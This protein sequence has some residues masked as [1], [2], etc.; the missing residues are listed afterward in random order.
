MGKVN[1]I[2]FSQQQKTYK[3]STEERG[4]FYIIAGQNRPYYTE[5]Y[6][7][8]TFG[9][10][11]VEKGSINLQAGLNK[12]TV[13]APAIISMGPS[14][15]RNFEKSNDES[16]M[17]IIFFTRE[18]LLQDQTNVFLLH[19]YD[20]FENNAK[21]V[22][23]LDAPQRDVFM[24]I[25]SLIADVAARKHTYEASIVRSYILVLINEIEVLVEDG[26][27]L[28]NQSEN[29]SPL[30][31]KFKSLLAEKYL[32]ERSVAFYAEQLHTTP[33]Y[34][35]ALVKK[36]TGRTAGMLINESVILEAK[37]LLQNH[38]FSI[39]QVSQHLN[40]SDQSVFGKY[41]KISTG[42]SPQEYRKSLS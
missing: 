40:F 2:K 38:R 5:P 8:E 20:F 1:T 22:I 37:V 27:D 15:I 29:M 32:E 30:F 10:A 33:K 39:G 3:L 24:R 16:L 6:R 9:I 35:S 26:K 21:H 34:L 17:H 14:V 12:H 23:A 18:Y 36:Q 11:L 19:Q 41:F 4:F 31:L 7:T 28:E 13:T 25:F 42:L